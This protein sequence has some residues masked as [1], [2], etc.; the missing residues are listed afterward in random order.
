[1]ENKSRLNDR[2][3]V[4]NNNALGIISGQCHYLGHLFM[5]TIKATV[6]N[7]GNRYLKK[8]T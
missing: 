1:M 3:V 7:K 6:M 8:L 5:S 4:S 2:L